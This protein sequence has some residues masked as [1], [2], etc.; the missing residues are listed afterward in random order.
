MTYTT[1]QLQA[2][3]DDEVTDSI[4][5]KLFGADKNQS[6]INGRTRDWHSLSNVEFI[7]EIAMSNGVRIVK[8]TEDETW[9]AYK[10]FVRRD[11][12]KTRHNYYDLEIPR[13]IACLLL[14]MGD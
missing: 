6:I 11:G 12:L 14:M 3:S 8:C 9:I 13:A 5:L 4:L 7:N 10:P 1:K 2:M